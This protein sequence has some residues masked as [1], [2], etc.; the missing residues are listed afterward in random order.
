MPK[1][2]HDAAAEMVADKKFYPDKS[3]EERKSIAW[4]IATK[5]YKKKKKQSFLIPKRFWDKFSVQSNEPGFQVV[6]IYLT[7]NRVIQG[8]KVYN[9][10][11]GVVPD[12]LEAPVENEIVDVEVIW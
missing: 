5:N 6:H 12:W 1:A 10:I 3:E 7:E 11:E 8:V 9:C 4:A 2:V